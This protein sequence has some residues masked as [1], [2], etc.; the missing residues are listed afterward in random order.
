M[1]VPKAFIRR[2]VACFTADKPSFKS[3]VRPLEIP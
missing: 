1:S 2:I 3:N